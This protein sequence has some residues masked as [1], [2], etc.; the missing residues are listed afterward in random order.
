MVMHFSIL[1]AGIE[2]DLGLAAFDEVIRSAHGV[3][4]RWQFFTEADDVFVA[5]RPVLEEPE[6]VE[7]L[8]FFLRDAHGERVERGTIDPASCISGRRN[9]ALEQASGDEGGQP[10][11]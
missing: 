11:P 2:P 9:E 5:F 3:I 4:D 1:E 10:D 7:E 8:L 6:F